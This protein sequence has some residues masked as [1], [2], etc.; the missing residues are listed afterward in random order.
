[1][2]KFHIIVNNIKDPNGVYTARIMAALKN[3]GAERVT[4][5]NPIPNDADA[6]I[7]L[8]GDGTMLRAAGN[9]L[10]L[11]IPL[12]GVN[13]GRLGYLTESDM[14]RIDEDMRKLIDGDYSIENRMMM[15]GKV[16]KGN[17]KQSEDHCLN[18][19]TITGCGA[20][21]LIRYD[22]FVNNEFL[23]SYSADGLVI[24]TPTGSTG[25]NMSAG[26]PIAQPR[27]NLIIVT[28]ICPHT[29]NS[30]SIVLSPDDRIEVRISDGQTV[31]VAAQ[32]DGREP[33][34]LGV[35]DCVQIF[36]S[37]EITKIIKLKKESF[38]N[39][40]HEKLI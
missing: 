5:G 3:A 23:N 20:L 38:L 35:G 16:Y 21:C 22:L 34:S 4:S 18:D 32:F 17:V 1:M 33:Y 29:L 19:I 30:R 26:G 13:L 39:T 25:Y 2:K 6:F 15:C 12:L 28:P 11:N 37:T 27:A 40:L 14:D 9:T 31:P 7:V 24:S 36:K 10:G 8:G